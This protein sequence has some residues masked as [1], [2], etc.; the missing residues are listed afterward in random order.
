[1]A[2]KKITDLTELTTGQIASDDLVFLYDAG[3]AVLKSAQLSVIDEAFTTAFT[4]TVLDDA[5]AEAV[6]T[7]LLMSPGTIRAV[8]VWIYVGGTPG[9][10]IQVAVTSEYNGATVAQ[11]GDI[12]KSGSASGISLDATGYKLSINTTALGVTTLEGVLSASIVL[13][14]TIYDCLVRPDVVGSQIDLYFTEAPQDA[15]GTGTKG[16]ASLDLT[17]ALNSGDN[18]MALFLSYATS[19]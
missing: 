18:E 17:S 9:T 19:E 10:N 15:E 11:T 2:D 3:A 6:K 8:A 5:S 4:R 16:G 13:N 7:T 12:A 1:M 14:K